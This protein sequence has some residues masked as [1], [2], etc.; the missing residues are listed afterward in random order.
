MNCNRS[1][2]ALVACGF[3]TVG[4]FSVSQ[5][6]IQW[7][8]NGH[9]YELVTTPL[10][11]N[12]AKLDA[13]S[14]TFLSVP[15]H[16]LTITSQEEQDFIT[17]VFGEALIEK[18]IGAFNSQDEFF[19]VTGEPWDYTNWDGVEPNG[20]DAVDFHGANALGTWNDI[21]GAIS[22]GYFVEYDVTTVVA[23]PMEAQDRFGTDR[24]VT[25]PDPGTFTTP[26]IELV[27]GPAGGVS[28]G[29]AL[30]F[31]SIG[32]FGSWSGNL[33]CKWNYDTNEALGTFDALNFIQCTPA[34]G[35]DGTVFITTVQDAGST[36]PG[37]VFAIDPDTMDWIWSFVTG[38]VQVSDCESYSPNVGPDGDIVV[39]STIGK[40]WRLDATTGVPVWD[41]TLG[42][43][44]Y[45]IPFS[46]DDTMVFA[47]N[48]SAMTAL[49]YADGSVAWSVTLGSRLG[50]PGVASDGTIVVGSVFGTVYGLDSTDGS[51]LWTFTALDQILAAPG[52]SADG[53]AY[54]SCYDHR[55]YALRVV[56]GVRIW[57]YTTS[58]EVH[59]APSVGHDGRIYV[60]NVVGDLYCIMPSGQLV[61]DVQSGNEVRG[62]IS[63]GPDGSVYVGL[64]DAGGA[65]GGLL[66]VHQD[67]DLRI[68]PDSFSI[69]RGALMGG[70]LSDLFLSDNMRL[71]VR[72]GLTLFLGESPLQVVVTATSSVDV[73]SELRFRLEAKVNTPGLTQKIELFNYDTSLYE[74]VDLAVPGASDGIVEVVI[75]TNPGRF[76][77]AGTRQMR[78]K[79]VY[80]QVGFTLLWPWSAGLDQAVWWTIEP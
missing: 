5:A 30:G 6:Q 34:I 22:L 1:R 24:A 68:L 51:T 17:N 55:V 69:V 65:T 36:R 18:W 21:T 19:W 43:C 45:T 42:E 60:G 56:D 46:R 58:D 7:S 79:L 37:R 12:D 74:E 54:V 77:Q 48:G 40:V 8:G 49:N 47:S 14:R 16:L 3:L 50:A 67:E 4:L 38:Y 9:M 78:A 75:T 76:V 72:A 53:I 52:F 41:A 32:Y 26:R 59:C 2:W 80:G 71:D 39:G 73:P 25:G 70:G 63:V 13:E 20:G 57:S 23:W 33:L 66:V 35:P 15:G 61:W 44:R 27:T 10:N 31:D 28:H 11:W 29:P 64:T 62:P